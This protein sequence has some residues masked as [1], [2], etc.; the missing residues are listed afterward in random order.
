[1][2]R[3]VWASDAVQTRMPQLQL[4]IFPAGATEINNNIAVQCK[5]GKV[6]YFHGH[7]PMFQHEENSVKSFRYFT[8]H[9]IDAGTIRTVDVARTFGVPLA[10]VK[11]YLK[12]YREQGTEE[13]FQRKPR[14]RSETKLT[15]EIKRQAQQLLEEGNNVAAVG[16]ALHVLPTT[17]H[18]AI[19]SQRLDWN[20]KTD[21]AP[22]APASTK[23]E[24]TEIDSQAPMGYAATRSLERVAATM[25]ELESAPI[26]FE[27]AADIP[28]GGVLLALPAL[29][30]AGLLR[31]TPT[32]YN[33]PK[34]YYGI[35]I[36]FLLLA[37]MAVGCLTILGEYAGG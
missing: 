23:S 30:A 34:G 31:H 14:L 19:R 3:G 22:S 8:S 17:L 1:L 32:F 26:E 9:M 25:G 35:E 28:E 24:R 10:T 7:L 16:R 27:A 33:L 2:R 5:D 21:N 36:I 29:L 13:F 20:K 12:Q 6:V 4:P 11:R 15:G 37:M 18:K